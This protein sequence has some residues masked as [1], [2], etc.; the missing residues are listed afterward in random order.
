M[1]YKYTN[2]TL[3]ELDTAIIVQN[4]LQGS[5]TITLVKIGDSWKQG[6][7]NNTTFTPLSIIS[8]EINYTITLQPGSYLLYLELSI[9]NVPEYAN[10]NSKTFTG[11]TSFEYR[12]LS[13]VSSYS[14]FFSI[15]SEINTFQLTPPNGVTIIK[16]ALIN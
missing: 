5:D 6:T 15:D 7:S 1:N 2:G 8:N 13:S 14:T 10:S 3:T 16:A 11:T 12:S 4:E 9:D